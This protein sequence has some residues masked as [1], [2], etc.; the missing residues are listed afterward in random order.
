[1]G[2]FSNPVRCDKCGRMLYDA[3]SIAR[4]LG[5]SCALKL[6]VIGPRARRAFINPPIFPE[7]DRELGLEEKKK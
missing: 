1:M 5:P 2:R 7:H 6:G 4:K 3:P